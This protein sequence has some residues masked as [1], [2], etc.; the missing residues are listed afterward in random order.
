MKFLNIIF[1]I[2][3]NLFLASCSENLHLTRDDQSLNVSFSMPNEVGV[4]GSV[5]LQGTC[6]PDSLASISLDSQPT[7]DFTPA[8]LTCDCQSGVVVNCKDTN[9]APIAQVVFS[10]DGPN[11]VNPKIVA[12]ITDPKTNEVAT[13]NPVTVVAPTVALTGPEIGVVNGAPAPL[14]LTGTCSY[15]GSSPTAVVTVV[16]SSSSMSPSSLSCVCNGPGALGALD[17][18]GAGNVTFLSSLNPVL[19]ATIDD[20]VSSTTSSPFEVSVDPVVALTDDPDGPF[21]VSD[22]IDM[23]GTCASMGDS[24]SI[25]N[26]DVLSFSP[27]GPLTCSCDGSGQ[28]D[29]GD[30]TVTSAGP[31][32]AEFTAVLTDGDS[33]TASDST[34]PVVEGPNLSIMK[35]VLPSSDVYA[36]TVLT[37]T[38]TVTNS[39]TLDATSVEVVDSCPANTTATG[40]PVASS[41]AYVSPNWTGATVTSGGGTE[42]LTFLCIVN[43]GTSASDGPIVSSVASLNSA[44]TNLLSAPS[45]GSVSSAVSDPVV[46]L[47]VGP[48]STSAGVA[49]NLPA[50]MGT[51][52]PASSV[53]SVTLIDANSSMSTTPVTCD[54]NAL[55]QIDC[56][57]TS[58]SFSSLD[59]DL[60][61]SITVNG[62]GPIADSDAGND[63]SVVVSPTVTITDPGAGPYGASANIAI[64]G[65]CE[66]TGD[67]IVV[68]ASPSTDLTAASVS[69]SCGVA[70][71]Y[72][73]PNF[74]T[75]PTGSA[76]TI[77][78]TATATD[79]DASAPQE[80]AM[81]TMTEDLSF[82]SSVPVA[83]S[84]VTTDSCL[85][86]VASLNDNSTFSPPATAIATIN[87]NITLNGVAAASLSGAPGDAIGQSGLTGTFASFTFDN[88]GD[89]LG[90]A[91]SATALDEICLV[92]SVVD[93]NAVASTNT[94]SSRCY[95][96]ASVQCYSTPS[97]NIAITTPAG[98][99]SLEVE[100]WGA[101]G[102][103]EGCN[104]AP[105]TG[106]ITGDAPGGVGGYAS[107][108]FST[109]VANY[110]LVVGEGGLGQHGLIS[111]LNLG[112]GS[113]SGGQKDGTGGGLS[114]L[115]SGTG[116]V[117]PTDTGRA[118][119][120]AGGGGG[121][122]SLCGGSPGL[123]GSGGPG[124]LSVAF[125]NGGIGLGGN[126]TGDMD[127]RIAGGGDQCGQGGGFEGGWNEVTGAYGAGGTCLVPV[128]GT[129]S[130]GTWKDPLTVPGMA[131]GC[132]SS[133]VGQAGTIDL[134]VQTDYDGH[135]GKICLK[136][137]K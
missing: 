1:L 39:G 19:S 70:N 123:D 54:C 87:W 66:S 3:L 134:V 12:T 113:S 114:G 50:N 129:V 73:C 133:G 130:T 36:A 57:A 55:G 45:G 26:P 83:S 75:N 10:G 7:G 96:Y 71:S 37:Y 86:N 30:Y 56:S 136:W 42:T 132:Y 14:A 115:F 64:A 58:V 91:L 68:T 67:S 125:P 121:G 84:T 48:G 104:T 89:D 18:S 94:A 29:C 85:E 98:A 119:L 99:T 111:S 23:N 44:Q 74:T 135:D 20:G 11:G 127:G 92:N 116:V 65:S 52:A 103:A 78:F 126:P 31:V 33:Q 128:G 47:A 27:V 90:V 102:G 120:V 40:T 79:Q 95:S 51:C 124:C 88:N 22:T 46:D 81:A 34:T 76:S 49:A 8:P 2:T 107:G 60:S 43:S 62:V 5:S 106:S 101:G 117:I 80:T 21:A 28:F 4:S 6:Y 93:D 137:R 24:I 69:C 109:L 82:G 53:G 108:T 110:T 38:I 105:C 16:D 61:A 17:C 131:S 25:A 9:D 35:A 118:L 97:E 72:T 77:T 15:A 100:A 13:S 32:S 59:P 122:G 112:F 41:G 63:P